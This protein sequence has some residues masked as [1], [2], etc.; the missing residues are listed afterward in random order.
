MG[1]RRDGRR[2]AIEE[3]EDEGLGGV[4]ERKKERKREWVKS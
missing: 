2:E 4:N 3:T 1:V